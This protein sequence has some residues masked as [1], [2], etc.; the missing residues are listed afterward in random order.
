MAWLLFC[1][2]LHSSTFFLF[3]RP[4][5][6][7]SSPFLF[8]SLCVCVFLF[9]SRFIHVVN[10]IVILSGREMWTSTEQNKKEK[11]IDLP[12]KRWHRY[13]RICVRSRFFFLF[14][15][16][17]SFCMLYS[18]FVR[19]SFTFNG[20]DESYFHASSIYLFQQNISN[21]NISIY[22]QIRRRSFFPLYFPSVSTHFSNSSNVF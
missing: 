5:M 16:P 1:L 18:H 19:Y 17:V 10:E 8:P 9:L 2:I 4:Y 20:M 14:T 6:C 21:L 11:E 12:S 13:N 15:R 22:I 7:L 3:H